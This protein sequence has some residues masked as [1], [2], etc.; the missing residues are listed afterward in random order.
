[1]R[2]GV[3]GPLVVRDDSGR[4]PEIGGPRLRSLLAALVLHANV[5]VSRDALAAAVWDGTP[6]TAA[7][8]TLRSYV[9]RLR[10]LLGAEAAAR[11]ETRDLGYLCRLAEEELDALRFERLCRETGAAL[12][13]HAWEQAARQAALA[14]ALWRGE[15]LLDVPSQLLR[16]QF[17]PRLEGL[18]LL[19]IECRVEAELNL[20]RH[21]QLILELR[22]L[23]AHHP[24]HERF[25][26]QLMLAL[27]RSGRQAESLEA[28][29]T[30]RG[31]LVEELGVEPGRELREAHAAVLSGNIGAT[32]AP[33]R[34]GCTVRDPKPRQL[35]AAARYFTGRSEEL[36]RLIKLG[37]A[38]AGARGETMLAVID[39]MAG[40][41]KT[42][43][44]VH[45]A[46][47]LADRFTDGQLFIDLHGHSR[48]RA[49]RSPGEALGTLLVGLGVPPGRIPRDTEARV[50]L[51]RQRLAE[52]RTLIVLDNAVNEAQVRPLLPAASGCLVL[53][54][55]R[56][57]LKGLDD[58]F[59]LPLDP[60]PMVTAAG[61][62]RAVAGPARAAADDPCLAEIAELCG[63]LPLALRIAA[64]ILRHR[65]SW[66][67]EH[68]AR[69][70][71]SRAERLDALSDGERDLAAVVGLSYEGLTDAQRLLFRHLGLIR[72]PDIDAEAAAA[73]LDVSHNTAERVLEEL[74]DQNVL[75]EQTLGRYQQHELVRLYAQ[76]MSELDSPHER[77]DAGNRLFEYYHHTALRADAL[78]TLYPAAAPA[79]PSPHTSRVPTDA[80]AAW[81]WLRAERLNLLAEAKH[82]LDIADG[83]RYVGLSLGMSTLLRV[84]GPW[85]TAADL[86]VEAVSLARSLGDAT[87]LA[88][89]LLN[90]AD[91]RA[92]LDD[93]PA[94]ARCVDE[95]LTLYQ[96]AG[97]PRGTATALTL[98]GEV[99]RR[100][101]EY[102]RA[103]EALREA[104][105]SYRELDERRG[106]ATV[107]LL[108]GEVGRMSGED[109]SSDDF[110]AALALFREL[111]EPRGEAV[112]LHWIGLAKAAAGD[113][114]GAVAALRQ[115]LE[116]YRGLEDRRGQASALTQLGY[117]HAS[118]PGR[119]S[120]AAEQPL[121]EA[122][123]LYRDLA[124]R[125]GRSDALAL[126]AEVRRTAGER[127]PSRGPDE[128]IAAL[129]PGGLHVNG[130][131][132]LALDPIVD[133]APPP[134]L[135]DGL[136]GR[137]GTLPDADHEDTRLA[138]PE[139]RGGIRDGDS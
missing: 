111:S 58:A 49:P 15:P 71:R 138:I 61:L 7:V 11:I 20:G 78:I 44:A 51:Y 65:P 103:R 73:L 133:P 39:G 52:T 112:A 4:E 115:A 88:H 125:R 3:L 84:D 30:A 137:L 70:F 59:L 60:M 99:R 132:R 134:R 54:T 40:V 98:S 93:Y 123:R 28:Y 57:R 74:V 68:L 2:F 63:Q 43:L 129:R 85:S 26:A 31:L 9:R 64:A 91:A 34:I 48:D 29:R 106:L 66:S 126:L 6:P 14:L 46:H 116:L 18:R 23:A 38:L 128:R 95:A 53:V 131:D 122:L 21:G 92:G 8:D 62:V 33:Q 79:G 1:M 67:P 121:E 13:E 100:M 127:A 90:L 42:A 109:E 37:D 124:D 55:S 114:E 135:P 117:A 82:A 45:A 96:K 110:Q 86:H 81:N 101:G 47:R 19:A 69:L 72:G 108:S 104:A 75:T 97:N 77:R 94:A 32:E 35:P 27:A 22:D 12:R 56:R 113:H 41:G 130:T 139:D 5:S 17:V 16:G 83:E 120:A 25:H 24:L 76:R 118:I 105:G 107:L 50:A 10:H 36:G 136:S 89:T 80:T 87:R 102:V 119:D